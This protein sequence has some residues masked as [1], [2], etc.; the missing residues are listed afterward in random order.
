MAKNNALIDMYKDLLEKNKALQREIDNATP[1]V[2]AGVALALHREYGWGYER[3]N[4]VFVRSQYIWNECED[5]NVDMK[6]L[7]LIETSIDL[8]ARTEAD[9]EETI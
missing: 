8:R 5:H 2:Y 1:N 3:I 4:K 6:E 9:N 7:C